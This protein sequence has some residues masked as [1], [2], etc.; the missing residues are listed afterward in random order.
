M[1]EASISRLVAT[2]AARLGSVAEARL[3]LAHV[4]GVETAALLLAAPPDEEAAARLE[5]ALVRR[6]YF[7]AHNPAAGTVWIFRDRA[8]GG[9]FLQGV[10][11]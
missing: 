7:I 4:L 1:P 8:T 5:A 9:W 6:D 2:T 3:L 11:G 10:Y